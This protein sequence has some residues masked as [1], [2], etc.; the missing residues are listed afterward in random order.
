MPETVTPSAA[1]ALNPAA[2]RLVLFGMPDAGKS[3]LLGALKQASQTQEALLNGH[4]IDRSQ[5][6]ADLQRRLYEDQPRETLEEIVPYP[7]SLEPLTPP[8]RPTPGSALEAVLVDCDGRVANQLLS[9]RGPLEEDGNLARAILDAD[10]LVFLV[11]AS[12]SPAQLE[13]D[14]GQFARFLDL[15]QKS[16]ARRSDVGGLPV[17]LVLT[18]CD[19][20]AQRGDTAVSWIDRIEE[21][22]RQ[23][24]LRFKEF[25]AAR[26]DAGPV[27]FGA[28]DL[29]LWATAVKR[30]AL[31]EAPARP[32]EPYGVAELFRQCLES[33]RSFHYREKRAGRRLGWTVLA[34]VGVVAL[35]ALLAAAFFLNQPGG[36]S[37]ALARR[38][39][40]Y[41]VQEEEQSLELKH[42]HLDRRIKA[43]SAIEKDP[44]FAALPQVMQDYVRDHR[45]E[46]LAYKKAFGRFKAEVDAIQDPEDATTEKELQDIEDKLG[47]VQVPAR[48][49][50]EWGETLEG[51]KLRYWKRDIDALR[52][53]INKAERWYGILLHDGREVLSHLD[54]P[55]LP[56][57]AK[58][59]LD[60]ARAGFSPEKDPD[61]PVPGAR[62]VTYS[63]VLNSQSVA[64]LRGEWEQ[65]KKKLE[66][67]TS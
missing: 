67:Y 12:A 28:I 17:Y 11:D 7:V 63:A 23:I 44:G 20:L 52:V 27:P 18:K 26:T 38:V 50:E 14:F 59:V 40:A 16:R 65:I 24:G 47:R 15:L 43:L 60:K 5:G 54:A 25:L 31:A 9:R 33:A 62:F 58:Q 39:E 61:R 34:S 51:K 29:H 13:R 22:K 32:R 30:P 4:L 45:Q 35:L 36:P 37:G 53:A 41:Q 21:R 46:L 10:T 64:E 56:K 1:P 6:L 66:R 55:N 57:R 42:H 2:V 8:G 3:S 48:Y 19:L 49:Q